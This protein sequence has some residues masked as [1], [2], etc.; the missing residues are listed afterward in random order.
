MISL[1]SGL[2]TCI[3]YF[4]IFLPVKNTDRYLSCALSL[5]AGVMIMISVLDLIPQSLQAFL[6]MGALKSCLVTISFMCIGL[7]FSFAIDRLIPDYGRTQGEKLSPRRLLRI[8]IISACAMILHNLP[9]GM[10]TF[11]AGYTNLTLGMSLAAAIALHNIPEGIS[12]AL[13]VYY[14]TSSKWKSFRLVLL[15]GLAEPLGAL[16]SFL[17]LRPL[18]S[19]AFSLGGI[20]AF[21]AG[22]MLH[23]SFGELLPAS[24]KLG[25]DNITL[26]SLFAGFFIIM[27]SH[28][29]I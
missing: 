8:G 27:I 9:E 15:T 4:I 13:P 28:S 24:R 29:L 26:F 22:I 23:I 1:V 11:L 16:L 2:A 10:A 12:I 6:Y 20:F 19:H 5:S 25:Y 18:A 21:C 3:G 7:L 17:L 14:S